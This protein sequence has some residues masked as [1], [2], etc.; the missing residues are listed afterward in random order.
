MLGT[1]TKLIQSLMNFPTSA[2]ASVLFVSLFMGCSIAD[3]EPEPEQEIVRSYT[4][5]VVREAENELEESLIARAEAIYPA[6]D[7]VL[8]ATFHPERIPDSGFW[9][10]AG[11]D[12]VLLPYAITVDAVA[13]YSNLI[14]ALS[15]GEAA[16]NVQ[17]LVRADLEYRAVVAFSEA[18]DL[19]GRDAKVQASFERVNVVELSLKWSEVLGIDHAMTFWQHRVIVF[20]EAGALV[21]VFMDGRPVIAVT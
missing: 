10:F 7:S 20:D 8:A 6:R 14:D 9:Y 11:F 12:R 19:L 3:V 2:I 15:K 21:G 13:Y 16:D 18:Y 17:K 5:S 4:K 1:R